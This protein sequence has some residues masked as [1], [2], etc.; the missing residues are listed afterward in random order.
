MVDRSSRF[1]TPEER[2][3]EL[4][5]YDG[6]NQDVA[7]LRC[8]PTCVLCYAMNILAWWYWWTC[9]IK[10]GCDE[11]TGCMLWEIDWNKLNTAGFFRIEGGNGPSMNTHEPAEVPLNTDVRHTNRL[12]CWCFKSTIIA[13]ASHQSN[14]FFTF[15]Q[16]E[17]F[18]S[19]VVDVITTILRC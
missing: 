12:I 8:W 6:H 16:H 14:L 18:C 10:N 19:I 15:T 1:A 5:S 4:M 11:S 3:C 17:V 7:V 9:P 13:F 2:N